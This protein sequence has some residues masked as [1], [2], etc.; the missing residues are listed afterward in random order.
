MPE[1]LLI[2]GRL[3]RGNDEGCVE[4][5]RLSGFEVD[6]VFAF[7]VLTELQMII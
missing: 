3:G 1:R 2:L 6:I 5:R 4:L 7:G